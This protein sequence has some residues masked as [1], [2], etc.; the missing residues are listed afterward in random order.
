MTKD[1]TSWLDLDDDDV[2]DG[3]NTGGDTGGPAY[4][5]TLDTPGGAATH[6]EPTGPIG[7]DARTTLEPTV[8]KTQIHLDGDFGDDTAPVTGWLVVIK[9]PGLGKSIPL[10]AGMNTIGRDPQSAVPFDFGDN[11]ISGQ[12]H[13]RLI[14]DDANRVFLV[15]PGGGRNLSRLNGQI[16]TQ[17]IELQSH[18]MLDLSPETRVCFVAFCGEQFDWSDLK[19]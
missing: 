6:I 16:I 14:Y 5:E 15:A 4:T 13:L 9:G 2:F 7:N 11:K 3:G 1:K 10:S 17:T 19:G 8:E 18:A 12:D